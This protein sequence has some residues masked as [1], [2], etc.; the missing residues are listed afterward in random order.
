VNVVRDFLSNFVAQI[1]DDVPPEE[2]Y[3]YTP[4][5]NTREAVA[6]PAD[7]AFVAAAFPVVGATHEDA[8]ALLLLSTHLSYGYLWEHIRVKGGAYGARALYDP[9]NGLFG[10]SSYR[11]PFIN[12]TLEV[13]RGVFDYIAKEM[14]LSNAAVEKAIIGTIK[15]IDRPIRPG[16]AVGLALI[17][18][19]KGETRDFRKTF[20]EK[21]MSLTGDEIR[22][23]S[24][25]RLEP[26]FKTAP[27]C[28][29]SS[30]EKLTAAKEAFGP[31]P[32]TIVDI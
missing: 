2:P 16:Q 5:L 26:A 4:A 11:D 29:L 10:F 6:T 23:V 12:E 25:E 1:R 8:P 21:L 18:H 28:V 20:R 3:H 7:V 31:E 24:V 32:L 19:L 9:L 27:I 15:T 17:R 13:Y 30:R 14:D 22:R